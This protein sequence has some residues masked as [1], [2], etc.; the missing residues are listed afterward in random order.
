MSREFRL[1]DATHAP[2]S[3]MIGITGAQHSGKTWSALR[4]ATGIC[5]VRGGKPFIIDTENCAALDYK[6]PFDFEHVDFQPPYHSEAY[7]DAV[8]FTV[9]QKAGCIIIDSMTHEHTGIGGV[10]ERFDQFLDEQCG[11]DFSKRKRFTGAAW[12]H[13]K[14]GRN[15]LYKHFNIVCKDT[16]VIMCFRAKDA[17]SYLDKDNEDKGQKADSTNPLLYELKINFLLTSGSEGTPILRSEKQ[18][19]RDII[20]LRA[21]FRDWF[22]PGK[23]VQIDE[24]LGERF[25]RWMLGPQS[26]DAPADLKPDTPAEEFGEY[27]EKIAD[28]KAALSACESLADLKAVWTECANWFKAGPGLDD[29]NFQT[30][31]AAKDKA[32]ARLEA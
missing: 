4:L 32:K 14:R 11:L 7:L 19:E 24:S 25:G 23:P 21:Q 26:G 5:K 28:Y 6:P 18:A 30:C 20:K 17:G 16:P 1:T 15:E 10:L 9:E 2:R 27:T 3:L 29:P 13:A 8:R 12:Q 31:T 22:Q